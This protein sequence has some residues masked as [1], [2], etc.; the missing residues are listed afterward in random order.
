MKMKAGV[1]KGYRSLKIEERDVPLLLPGHALI[2]VSC[3]GLSNND[4]D[5]YYSK[6]PTVIPPRILGHEICGTVE[7]V[8]DLNNHA[9]LLNKKVV[10]DPIIYCGHCLKCKK[11]ITNHCENI[12]IIGFDRDGGLAEFVQVPTQNLYPVSQED[13]LEGFTIACSLAKA[14][15]TVSKI[16]LRNSSN[17]IILGA[18][19]I[20]ILCGLLLIEKHG[21][22]VDIA[23]NNN[24]RLNIARS[25][26]L[27][28]VGDR[29]HNLNN[30]LWKRD[31]DGADVIIDVSGES[32]YLCMA[33]RLV[34]VLGKIVLVE[35][36]PRKI[37]FDFIT[38]MQKEVTIVSSYMYTKK[39]F[40]NSVEEISK[41]KKVYYDFITQRL[42]MEG[43]LEGMRILENIV[44]RMGVIICN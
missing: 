28:C 7:K 13:E 6:I 20:G 5:A 37:T 44:E 36:K 14:M 2:K 1:Y 11:G 23:D 19:T 30:I 24:F 42:P 32:S 43:I 3:C 33:A 18:N 10:V 27:S 25:L 17:I 16:D 40:N 31:K 12:E 26:G 4:I 9:N 21:H 35:S 15:H 29:E 38:I 39:D 8:Y 41:K 34:K 22:R